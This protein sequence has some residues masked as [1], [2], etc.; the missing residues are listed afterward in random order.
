MLV[1]MCD[2]IVFLCDVRFMTLL[3]PINLDFN[4]GHTPDTY[5]SPPPISMFAHF[6]SQPLVIR[7]S[8]ILAVVVVVIS[9]AVHLVQ[10]S[11]YRHQRYLQSVKLK[12]YDKMACLKGHVQVGVVRRCNCVL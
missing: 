11:W 7:V 6:I 1:S 8:A 10:S 12:N 3:P 4:L 9:Y 2:D 5:P